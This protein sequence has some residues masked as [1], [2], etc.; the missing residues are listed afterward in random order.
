MNSNRKPPECSLASINEETKLQKDFKIRRAQEHLREAA[1]NMKR[2]Y[3]QGAH[4]YT[5]TVGDQVYVKRNAVKRGES[6]KLSPL[7]DNPSEVVEVKMTLLK[8]KKPMQKIL[9]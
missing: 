7:F 1:H 6:R 9:F 2:H 4:E 5:V 8:I 3:D